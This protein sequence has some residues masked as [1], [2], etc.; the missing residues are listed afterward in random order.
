VNFVERV[1][2]ELAD[3]P[4]L[5]AVRRS[6]AAL[7][8]EYFD[9]NDEL[10]R[11]KLRHALDDPALRAATLETTDAFTPM[12]RARSPPPPADPATTSTSRSQPQ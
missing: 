10:T 5:A 2:Q 9:R 6:T 12:S 8:A 4:P 3:H 11:R 7:M 1:E